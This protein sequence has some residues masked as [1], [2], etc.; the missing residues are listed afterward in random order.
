M[1][2]KTLRCHIDE[3]NDRFHS[4]IKSHLSIVEKLKVRSITKTVQA[5]KIGEMKQLTHYPGW[6]TFFKTNS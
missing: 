1:L 6:P 3:R 5:T 4:S 2:R